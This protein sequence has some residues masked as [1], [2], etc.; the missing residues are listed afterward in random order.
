MARYDVQ[1]AESLGKKLRQLQQAGQ[2]RVMRTAANFAMTPVLQ[3]A[4]ANAPVGDR[5]H[6][7]YKGRTV[8]PGFLARSIKKKVRLSKDKSRV[9]SSVSAPGEAW[10]GRLI[11]L[12]YRVGGRSKAVKRASRK[13]KGGLSGA[14]LDSLG[15]SRAQVAPRPW[16]RPAFNANREQVKTRFADKMRQRIRIEALKK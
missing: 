3:A 4:R 8:A 7:T 13:T 12:G 16:L 1:N 9:Y 2:A 6:K 11:E 14:A 10:Y 15:D 5:T